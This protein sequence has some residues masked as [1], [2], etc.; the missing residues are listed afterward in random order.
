MLS[1]AFNTA[2]NINRRPDM[3]QTLKKIHTH[4]ASFLNS[5]KAIDWLA[6]KRTVEKSK[7]PCANILGEM[8]QYVLRVSGGRDGKFLDKLLLYWKSS[9]ITIAH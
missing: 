9:A 7:P 2:G 4:A 3:I 6:V 1:E 5:D 8:C